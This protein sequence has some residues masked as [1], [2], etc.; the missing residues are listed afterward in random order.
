MNEML[1]EPTWM[2]VGNAAKDFVARILVQ[3]PKDRMSLD[4]MLQHP[5]MRLEGKRAR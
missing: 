2:D 3:R 5:W 1:K 4:K